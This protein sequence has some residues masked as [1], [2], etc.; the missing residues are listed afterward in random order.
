M[1][2]NAI[3]PVG[4]K[5]D[6]EVAAIV[7]KLARKANISHNNAAFTVSSHDVV[8]R[9]FEFPKMTH[10][11][12]KGAVQL[13]VSQA[14]S[15]KSANM[16][17]DF[18]VLANSALQDVLYVAAPK[19]EIESRLQ[20]VR[21]AGFAPTACDIGSL[22]L[23]NCFWAFDP[24]PAKESVVLLDIGHTCSNISIV[25]N[26]EL[27]FVRSIDC[28]GRDITREISNHLGISTDLAETIKRKPEIWKGLGLNM[29]NILKKSLPD[30]LEGVYRSV[31]YCMTRKKLPFVDKILLTGGSSSLLGIDDFITESLGFSTKKWNPLTLTDSNVA[32][33]RQWGQFL[34]VAL[35][36]A[37][38]NTA[39][40]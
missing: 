28:G 19:D 29:T 33:Y 16:Y 11:E 27:R 6:N 8:S 5:H 34:S 3:S 17:S 24:N 22:A 32:A 18:V 40:L 37:L 25:D 7:S 39:G 36:L 1:A 21:K 35:G 12:L 20:I 14:S 13:E 15:L 2:R 4:G 23:T 30:M 9:N 31:E 10:E 38:R 26:E